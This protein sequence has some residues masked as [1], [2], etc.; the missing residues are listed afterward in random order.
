MT[1]RNRLGADGDLDA[2]MLAA[3]PMVTVE[4]PMTHEQQHVQVHK[5][6]K[7]ST[8]VDKTLKELKA[9]QR[10]PMNELAGHDKRRE[11]D[12]NNARFAGG[13]SPGNE[14]MRGSVW[15]NGPFGEDRGNCDQCE[16]FGSGGKD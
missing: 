12:Q 11:D 16:T 13:D 10:M 7:V 3:Q 2:E 1:A 6:V 4:L 14:G 8:K 9:D 5:R 15:K